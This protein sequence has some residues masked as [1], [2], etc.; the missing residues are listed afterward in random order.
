[1]GIFFHDALQPDQDL[2]DRLHQPGVNIA[3][4]TPEFVTFFDI[5]LNVEDLRKFYEFFIVFRCIDYTFDC[6][7]SQCFSLAAAL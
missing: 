1:M 7:V 2:C 3:F 5:F 6:S 4:I